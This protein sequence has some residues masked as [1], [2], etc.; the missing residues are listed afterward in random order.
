MSCIF[1]PRDFEGLSFPHPAF[2][3]NSIQGS[4]IGPA[5]YF[6]TAAN[7]VAVIQGNSRCK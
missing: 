7:L 1:T 5:S 2:S 6:V 4:A 3:V